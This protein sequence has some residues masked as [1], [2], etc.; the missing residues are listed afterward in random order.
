MREFAI[1]LFSFSAIFVAQNAGANK[2]KFFSNLLEKNKFELSDISNSVEVKLPIDSA[3]EAVEYAKK[4]NL[5]KELEGYGDKVYVYSYQRGAGY[6]ISHIKTQLKNGIISREQ[7]DVLYKKY[8]E[9]GDYWEVKY[10]T[11]GIIPSLSCSKEFKPSGEVV[12]IFEHCG[13]NK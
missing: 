8:E 3:R 12:S 11:S 1:L 9:L 6:P 2:T 4:Y 13:W 7:F 10:K 5:G